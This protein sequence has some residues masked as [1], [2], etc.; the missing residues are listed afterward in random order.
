M[1]SLLRLK[2]IK[3]YIYLYN[4]QDVLPSLAVDIDFMTNMS[5]KFNLNLCDDCLVFAGLYIKNR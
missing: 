2:E 5:A 3:D 1:W 4:M